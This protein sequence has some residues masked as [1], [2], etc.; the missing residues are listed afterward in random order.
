MAISSA[1]TNGLRAERRGICDAEALFYQ[2]G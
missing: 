2:G 1:Q